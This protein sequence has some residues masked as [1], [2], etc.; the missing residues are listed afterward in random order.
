MVVH[1]SKAYLFTGRPQLDFFDLL[2]EKWGSVMTR[3]K[4][5]QSWPYEGYS[6]VDYTM[7]LVDGKLFVFGGSH[8]GSQ[9]GCNVLMTLDL[10]ALECNI[11]LAH[12]NRKLTTR[13][14]AQ[15]YTRQVG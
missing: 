11:F 9:V 7:Q 8:F 3:T 1:K 6:L 15:G 5:D 2:T 14:L 10:E 13:A 4:S 12:R